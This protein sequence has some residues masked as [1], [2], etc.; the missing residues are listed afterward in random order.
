[1]VV[2]SQEW[3]IGCPELVQEGREVLRIAN[4]SRIEFRY[5]NI[6]DLQL[7]PS[8]FFICLEYFVKRLWGLSVVR[9]GLIQNQNVRLGVTL[10]SAAMV[11]ERFLSC[12]DGRCV[13][14]WET[15]WATSVLEVN[16][17]GMLPSPPTD[18]LPLVRS[19]F[20]DL[21]T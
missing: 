21:W 17:I 10:L 9:L 5:G 3:S 16:G 6:R 14:T 1:M 13:K 2:S 11:K 20:I 8:P 18:T 7:L 12:S 19:R 4:Y 15:Y